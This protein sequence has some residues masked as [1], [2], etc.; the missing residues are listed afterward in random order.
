MTLA[1]WVLSLLV[2]TGDPGAAWRNT[3]ETTA[4]AFAEHSESSPL[5]CSQ[6]SDGTC[7]PSQDDVR[8]TAALLVSVSWFESR[9]N[10]QAKGDSSCLE[11]ASATEPAQEVTT[12]GDSK[13][14]CIRRGPPRSFCLGQIHESNFVSLGVTKDAILGDVGVCVRAMVALLR[15][16]MKVC[17]KEPLDARLSWY[18]A[19]GSGCRPN[20]ESRH[21]MRKAQWLYAHNPFIGEIATAETKT[22]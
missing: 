12:G 14:A 8:K 6:R 11:Y 9:H 15:E 3:Y 21:R 16:S 13:R 20:K 10:P 5:F 17:A 1:S 22:P 7:A 4:E 18:A 19:G 2:A